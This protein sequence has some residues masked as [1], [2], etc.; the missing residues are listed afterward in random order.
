MV[1]NCVNPEC[2][3]EFLYLR[4]GELFVVR[5]QH[6]VEYFWLCPECSV[7]YRV[8]YEPKRGA[9]IVAKTPDQPARLGPQPAALHGVLLPAQILS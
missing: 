6:S 5:S 1:S 9:L 3:N 7:E 2:T 8:V 4:D